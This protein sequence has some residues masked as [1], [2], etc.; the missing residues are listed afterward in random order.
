[1]SVQAVE[2]ASTL[3]TGFLLLLG[4]LLGESLLGQKMVI[5]SAMS[6]RAVLEVVPETGKVSVTEGAGS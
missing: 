4:G 6:L 3:G 2:S 5:V 1:M